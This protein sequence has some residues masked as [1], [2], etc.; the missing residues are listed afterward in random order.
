MI[1]VAT[2]FANA[3][4]DPTIQDDSIDTSEAGTWNAGVSGDG[5]TATCVI[6]VIPR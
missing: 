2:G 6:T 3:S 5:Q 4:A 1:A